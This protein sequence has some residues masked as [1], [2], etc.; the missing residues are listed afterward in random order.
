MKCWTNFESFDR[1]N[2]NIPRRDICTTAIASTSASGTAGNSDR[3]RSVEFLHPFLSFLRGHKNQHGNTHYAYS[4]KNHCCSH[5]P[6]F[7]KCIITILTIRRRIDPPIPTT[8]II[9]LASD[10]SSKADV[11]ITAVRT[12]FDMSIMKSETFS[13]IE[14]LFTFSFSIAKLIKYLMQS[15]LRHSTKSAVVLL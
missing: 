1:D 4:K 11:I 9:H 3:Y 2:V 13:Q 15:K 10:N 5:L 6:L 7:A 8:Y 12:Y 14:I